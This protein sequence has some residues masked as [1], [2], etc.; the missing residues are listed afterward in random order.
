MLLRIEE[1]AN[2]DLAGGLLITDKGRLYR[3]ITRSCFSL[4]Y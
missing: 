3:A 2:S 1:P 4:G